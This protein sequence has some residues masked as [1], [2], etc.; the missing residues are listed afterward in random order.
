MRPPLTPTAVF[1]AARRGDDLAREVV[2]AEARRLALAIAVVAPILDP[3]L[4]ILAGGIARN[5]ADLLLEP[6]RRELHAVSP[7]VPRL[8]VSELGEEAVLDGAVATALATAQDMLFSRHED[9]DRLRARRADGRGSPSTAS[10]ESR[11]VAA[12]VPDRTHPP[13][14]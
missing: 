5:N 1:A 6:L 2:S 7:F 4:V 9:L 8:A 12:P 13:H 14:P 11:L 10:P 3:Q